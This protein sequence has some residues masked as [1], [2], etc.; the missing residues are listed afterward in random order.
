MMK[1]L[2]FYFNERGWEEVKSMSFT[3]LG[4]LSSIFVSFAFS[5]LVKL[6][7]GVALDSVLA[8]LIVA[9]TRSFWTALFYSLWP[10]KFSFSVTGKK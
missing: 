8:S 3:F 1:A 10:D 6:T 9:F 2:R 5:D 4:V 7:Q